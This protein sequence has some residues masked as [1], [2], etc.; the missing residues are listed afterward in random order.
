LKGSEIRAILEENA[1]EHLAARIL[2][3][4]AYYYSKGDVY[5]N[6]ITGGLNFT[7]DM[8]QPEGSRVII[9][10]FSDGKSFD[11]NSTYNVAVITY[12]VGN[13]NCGL[14]EYTED[15]LIWGMDGDSDEGSV[16]ELIIKYLKDLTAQ[17]KS[18]TPEM[19]D[20]KWS[21]DYTGDKENLDLPEGDTA[22]VYSAELRDGKRYVIRQESEGCTFTS[23]GDDGSVVSADCPASGNT[24]AAPLP[25]NTL[26]LTA[27]DEGDGSWSFT[28]QNGRSFSLIDGNVVLSLDSKDSEESGIW[29]TEKKDGGYFLLD[30]NDE[31]RALQLYNGR[32]MTFRKNAAGGFYYNFYEVT[33]E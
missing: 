31:E 29:K 33:G 17:G 14:R 18:I 26:I 25:D 27:H 20:W 19:A 15:D 23:E 21:I 9:S 2:E 3:G 22:A 12:L 16:Q 1:A 28:D 4:K 32:F 7:Y 13:E 5:A 30:I 10:G 11:D 24:I 8:S 6:I